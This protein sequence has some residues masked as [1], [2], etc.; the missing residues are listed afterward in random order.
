MIVQVSLVELV[1]LPPYWLVGDAPPLPGASA[2]GSGGAISA[3]R[4]F[5]LARV[6]RLLTKY[7]LAPLLARY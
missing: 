6:L 4:T 3:L 2:G 1:L 5:R 7:V